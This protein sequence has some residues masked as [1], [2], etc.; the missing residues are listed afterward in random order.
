MKFVKLL[1]SRKG[2][3]MNKKE[4]IRFISKELKK[5]PEL[6][7]NYEYC[8]KVSSTRTSEGLFLDSLEM[9]REKLE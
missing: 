4:V 1:K 3:K 5:L 7:E 8:L 2:G 6:K 9:R